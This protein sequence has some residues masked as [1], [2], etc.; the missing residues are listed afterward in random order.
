M[1]GTELQLQRVASKLQ[2]GNVGL[3]IE[4]METYLAAYP[5]PQTVERLHG[6]KAEYELMTDYWKRGVNDPQLDQLYR[7]LLQRVYVLYA[8]IA[9]YYRM[10]SYP[11]LAGLYNR[12]RMERKDWFL[13]DIRREMEGFVSDIAMLEL[14]PENS[15]QEKG[16]QLYKEHQAQMNSLFCYVLTSRMWTEGVGHDF[17]EILVSP[18]IDGNDQQLLVSAITLSLLNQYDMVKFRVLANTY[19]RSQEE[20]VRQR[21]L[22]GWALAINEEVHAVY[23]EQEELVLSLL[24]SKKVCEELTELQMQLVYCLNAEKDNN[25]I[26]QEIMPD[27]IKNNNLKINQFSIEEREEDPM[28][29]ILHPEA[30]E[31]RMEKLEAT[32][33]RMMDMQKQGS[34]IYFGGFS[35]MKRFPFFYDISNWLVPFYLQHPDIVHFVHRM[36]GNKFVEK[37][38]QTGPFC[39]SDK[40]SFVIAFQQVFERIPEGM[41]KMLE[42][43]EATMGEVPEEELHTPAFIRRAYL[44][45]LYRFYRLFPSRNEFENPFDTNRSE[46]GTCEFF[47]H[48]LFI[49]SPLEPYKDAIVRLL[50]RQKLE[51]SAMRLLDTYSEN[52]HTVQ[53]YIWSGMYQN[54]L[55]LE[56]NNV[57]ALEGRAREV[58]NL[59]FYEEALEIYDDLLLLYP[60]KPNYLLNKAICLVHLT[61]YEEAQ[62]ILYRLNYDNPEDVRVNR[63]LAWANLCSG[64]L[65]QADQIYQK[66]TASEKPSSEDWQNAGYCCWLM[67]RIDEAAHCFKQYCASFAPDK[68]L[69]LFDVSFLREH[70]IS[71]TQ[72]KL[73]D[74]LVHS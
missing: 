40:Y 28:E 2:Q 50:K 18:T 34:D 49:D 15:R 45:D 4:E 9:S 74:A 55:A 44:M 69:F 63:V 1:T 65:A 11:T 7:H 61:E 58:F 6:I 3:A 72:I 56:P 12:V 30:S 35:Q 62:K 43:G 24:S 57:R 23:P 73:M 20:G 41:R 19:R 67:G 21:A 22:V 42:R 38:M 13:T 71:D 14:E 31:Q 29:D 60:D 36:Q 26:Q 32:F 47:C 33:G 51:E 70:G 17:E 37:M 59:G 68:E 46:L 8:N 64:K 66:L 39:N 25:T 16:E 52:H 10:R 54:A 5:Q 48:W 53:Y 27:L